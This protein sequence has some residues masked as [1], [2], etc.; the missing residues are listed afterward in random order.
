MSHLVIRTFRRESLTSVCLFIH[1]FVC[2]L[3]PLKLTSFLTA[4]PGKAGKVEEGLE[5][6]EQS[7]CDHNDVVDILEEDHHHGGV[8]NALEDGCELADNLH[9]SHTQVLADRDLQE[10]E[11]DA[12]YQHG[13]EVGD[14]ESPCQ[15]RSKFCTLG[16]S[17]WSGLAQL[18]TLLACDYCLLLQKLQLQWP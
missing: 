14:E 13:E 7:P 3:P 18:S 16:V 5:E 12:T 2:C 1:L 17:A 8:A 11:W 15:N 9:A 6:V 10:E 4:A